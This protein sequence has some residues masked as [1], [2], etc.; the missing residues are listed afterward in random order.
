MFLCAWCKS[1]FFSI[2]QRINLR[3]IQY[4]QWRPLPFALERP[5]VFLV[6]V[7][8]DAKGERNP[9]RI[10]VAVFRNIFP[11]S[12][13]KIFS[14]SKAS[15][16]TWVSICYFASQTYLRLGRTS[17]SPIL[18]VILKVETTLQIEDD[19]YLRKC[20]FLVICLTLPSKTA[21]SFSFFKFFFLILKNY[22]KSCEIIIYRLQFFFCH[23]CPLPY[24]MSTILNFMFYLLI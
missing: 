17:E 21:A 16:V 1:V 6:F 24:F 5:S 10:S 23:I 22:F 8:I 20:L 14:I 12:I 7:A 9:C 13:A 2:F 4:I 18:S 3:K 11:Q 15:T 19:L